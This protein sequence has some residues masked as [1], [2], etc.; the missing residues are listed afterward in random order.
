[1][2]IILTTLIGWIIYIKGNDRKYISAISLLQI[3]GVFTFSVG[4]HERYLFPAV[5]LSILAFIYSKDRR[6]F[7]MAIGFSITSY[8]NISTVFFKTNTS[9][10]E[11]LLKVTSLFNV[12]L[13]L[14][15]VKVIIDN[16]VKKFSLKIDNKESELL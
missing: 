5:A 10:F 13:V 16:T 1:M 12:I 3:A 14:Y 11:I 15:L 8:I 4:M 6:F 9:I 2:F 7:I